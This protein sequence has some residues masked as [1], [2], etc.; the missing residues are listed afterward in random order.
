MNS[1]E[2]LNAFSQGLIEFGDL[3]APGVQFDVP[4]GVNQTV[5]IYEGQNHNVPVGFEIEAIRNYQALNLFLQIQFNNAP[6]G[7]TL[8]FDTLPAYMSQSQVGALYQ[9][10]VITNPLDWNIVKSPVIGLPND[11]AGSFTYTV[12][13]LQ[14]G[15]NIIDYV[16]TVNV[17]AVNLITAPAEFADH[18]LWY[19]NNASSLSALTLPTYVNIDSSDLRPWNYNLGETYDNFGGNRPGPARRATWGYRGPGESSN[20]Q[21]ALHRDITRVRDPNT[22][23]IYASGQYSDYQI[24]QIRVDNGTTGTS[25]PYYAHTTAI[26]LPVIRDP[27]N[28]PGITYSIQIDFENAQAIQNAQPTDTAATGGVSNFSFTT[29]AGATFPTKR[30][31]MSG[32]LSQVN[33]TLG[34]SG[35]GVWVQPDP[36]FVG[37]PGSG[38]NTLSSSGNSGGINPRVDI[39]N[40]HLTNPIANNIYREHFLWARHNDFGINFTCE[41][42]PNQQDIFVTFTVTSSLNQTDQTTYR[43]CVG[44]CGFFQEKQGQFGLQPTKAVNRY[45][46]A[47]PGPVVTLG[48]SYYTADNRTYR[49]EN[50]LENLSPSDTSFFRALAQHLTT[51][52]MRL[53][54]YAFPYNA[55]E[56]IRIPANSPAQVSLFKTDIQA[57]PLPARITIV[58]NQQYHQTFRLM[59]ISNPVGFP[60]GGG[61]DIRANNGLTPAPLD[62]L[63]TG[64]IGSAEDREKFRLQQWKTCR[65]GAFKNIDINRFGNI[66]CMGG[67]TRNQPIV[68]YR[69]NSTQTFVPEYITTTDFVLPAETVG[70]KVSLNDNG[71]KIV[72]TVQEGNYSVASLKVPYR[73]NKIYTATY[74]GGVWS[75]RAYIELSSQDR[76]NLLPVKYPVTTA[77][78]INGIGSAEN[79]SFN[80]IRIV[81]GASTTVTIEVNGA[82]SATV[83]PNFLPQFQSFANNSNQRSA[84]VLKFRDVSGMTQINNGH[85]LASE[86]IQIPASGDPDSSPPA[87]TMRFRFTI[88]N[89]SGTE[90]NSTQWG[91]FTSGQMDVQNSDHVVFFGED[92]AQSKDGNYLAVTT[93]VRQNINDNSTANRQYLRIYEWQPGNNT[94]LFQQQISLTNNNTVWGGAHC[95]EFDA[96]GNTLIAS[97]MGVIHFI[98]KSGGVYSIQQTHTSGTDTNYY[99]NKVKIT[100]DGN[101]AFVSGESTG[102]Q[103]WTRVAGVWSI[104]QTISGSFRNFDINGEG[105]RIIALRSTGDF[106]IYTLQ[107]NNLYAELIVP[108]NVSSSFSNSFQAKPWLIATDDDA[109]TIIAVGGGSNIQPDGTNAG[110]GSETVLIDKFYPDDPALEPYVEQNTFPTSKRFVIE[111]SGRLSSYY[112]QYA[113]INS[114]IANTGTS[115]ELGAQITLIGT[116]AQIDSLQNLI[117]FKVANGY[118]QKFDLTYEWQDLNQIARMPDKIIRTQRWLPQ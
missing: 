91:N 6:A 84:D 75:R 39:S 69:K 103:V 54:V 113:E 1:L 98:N 117:S 10:G 2:E 4:D 96:V 14:N 23:R 11:Y 57:I 44:P 82:T 101:K 65:H 25:Y 51:T 53:S 88:K 85:F 64:G 73:S 37:T 27:G 108:A 106:K 21:G 89:L 81:K 105:S 77:Q 55:L 71:D 66:W 30:I 62:S 8:T 60:Y 43:V 70:T 26:P 35:W 17:T 94:W 102:L 58:S 18:V 45:A 67:G 29:V 50:Y 61:G 7:V 56:Y 97:G 112:M 114:V 116:G 90:V 36:T 34:R 52:T 79:R 76:L 118:N 13:L 111:A 68:I 15:V 20:I 63:G 48:S 33:K 78:K 110:L 5:N 47:T 22:G 9:V 46:P 41:T 109:Q 59:T 3:R 86:Q 99:G 16:V 28:T 83:N 95:I 19:Q 42:F 115:A 12:R 24:S 107:S 40:I 32:T 38:Q 100:R 92:I 49:F 31:T 72:F 104:V 93:W 74:A 87:G 80:I